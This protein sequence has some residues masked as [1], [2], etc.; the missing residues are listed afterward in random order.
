MK[1]QWALEIIV[2]RLNI[3]SIY[4]AGAY[5]S[6]KV[7][8]LET[9]ESYHGGFKKTSDLVNNLKITYSYFNEGYQPLKRMLPY[10][11]AI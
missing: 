8:F 4:H 3:S 9:P 1:D 6:M 2:S 10:F 11:D 7:I 5:N